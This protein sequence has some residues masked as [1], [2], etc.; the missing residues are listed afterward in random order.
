MRQ[1]RAWRDVLVSSIYL[2][3][4]ISSADTTPIH[5]NW[6][7]RTYGPDG[8]WHAIT[9]SLGNPKQK[10]DLFPGGQ[11]KSFVLGTTV[12]T[13][14]TLGTDCPAVSGG[15]WNATLASSSTALTNVVDFQPTVDW[16]LPLPIQGQSQVVLDDLYLPYDG[17]VLRVHNASIA[18]VEWA[19]NTYPNGINYP[20]TLGTLCLGAGT[21]NFSFPTGT[22]SVQALVNGSILQS[23]LFAENIIPSASYGLHVGSVGSKIP[24]SLWFGGYDQSR[25]LGPVASQPWTPLGALN[26]DLLDIQIG[27]AE[28]SSP[29]PFENRT[30]ILATGNSSIISSISIN[31]EPATPYMFLPPSTCAAITA[32]LPGIFNPALVFISGIRTMSPMV[33]L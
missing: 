11:F 13:N 25:V 31:I 1:I 32:G 7:D 28:G 8:P 9:V 2:L 21:P 20:V 27:V 6:S 30:G 33:R 18:S 5:I 24:P 29:F 23:Y 12:C 16:T 14:S 10:V 22:G 15:V 4:S 3:F 26:I 19:Y 17:P